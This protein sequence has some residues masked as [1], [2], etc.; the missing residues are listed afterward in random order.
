V[1]HMKLAPGVE[2][3]GDTETA[4]I[5]GASGEA[6]MVTFASPPPNEEL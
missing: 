4:E 1:Q 2:L 3:P 5:L 6:W